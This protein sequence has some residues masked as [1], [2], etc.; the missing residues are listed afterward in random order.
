MYIKKNLETDESKTTV[1]IRFLIGSVFLFEGIQ[2]FVY[3]AQRGAG[4]FESIGFPF[5]ELLASTAGGF[6]II[7]GLLMLAGFMT[8]FAA[9]SLICIMITALLTTKLPILFAEKLWELTLRDLNHYGIQSMM[10][11][12]RTG[13]S[14]LICSIFL[15]IKGGADGLQT[16]LFHESNRSYIL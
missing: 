11:E 7:C 16:I 1:L 13:L 4:R 9:I 10:H 3:P 6:E 2:K 8:R 12:S 15:L 14:M 5:P